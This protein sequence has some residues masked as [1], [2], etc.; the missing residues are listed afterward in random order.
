MSK[1]LIF[2]ILIIDNIYKKF[3]INVI[4]FIANKY[5]QKNLTKLFIFIYF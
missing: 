3:K 2:H 5:K 1:A 4:D